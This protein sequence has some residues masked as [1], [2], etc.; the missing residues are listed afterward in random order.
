MAQVMLKRYL[1]GLSVCRLVIRADMVDRETEN[2]LLLYR[3]LPGLSMCRLVIRADMA[4]RETEN[5]LLL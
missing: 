2:G 3:Y 4:D 5:G 1:P